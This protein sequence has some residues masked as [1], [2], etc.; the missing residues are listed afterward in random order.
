MFRS[1]LEQVLCIRMYLISKNNFSE[2][3]KTEWSK[4]SSQLFLESVKV[5][6]SARKLSS[7]QMCKLG[8][9]GSP[10]VIKLVLILRFFIF[11]GCSGT[12]ALMRACLAAVSDL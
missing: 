1:C 9:S 3:E 11:A 12:V 2:R 6:D 5:L 8:P 7:Y 10:L 4:V